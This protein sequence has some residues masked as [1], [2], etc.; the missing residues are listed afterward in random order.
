MNIYQTIKENLSAGGK[1][2]LAT[3]ISRSGSAPRDVGAKMFVDESGRSWG[4][5]GGG[6]LERYV[7]EAAVKRKNESKAAIFHM[8]MDSKTVAAQGMLCGG[9]VDVLL[10]P[11]V[12]AYLGLYGRLADMEQR[13]DGLAREIDALSYSL[14]QMRL[15]VDRFAGELDDSQPLPEPSQQ[16][17]V[18]D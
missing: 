7:Q 15:A 4:T 12:Q 9:N 14:S 17:T 16:E 1:G 5:I 13:G 2:V 10:E 11:V 3:V 6:L 8:K 18:A